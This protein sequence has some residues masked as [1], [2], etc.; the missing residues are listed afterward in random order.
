MEGKPIL[1]IDTALETCSV[2][3]AWE[4]GEVSGLQSSEIN[5]H[6]A[7]LATFVKQLLDESTL[8]IKDL[9]AVAVNG[10]PG[11]YTG[12]R[13]G[14]ALAKGLCVASSVP[15]ISISCL[16]A[17]AY[18]VVGKFKL[19][20]KDFVLS[21]IDA[22]REDVYFAMYQDSTLIGE[23]TAITLDQLW[24]KSLPRSSKIFGA[25][26]GIEKMSER[27]CDLHIEL[28]DTGI[29]VTLASSWAPLAWDA[30]RR[31]S[32]EDVSSFE[33]HYIKPFFTNSP[34]NTL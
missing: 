26:S 24:F 8:A 12:L 2:A 21:S 23:E 32:F 15:F 29:K 28:V 13:I 20:P 22:R 18:E 9:A 6:S 4:D 30:Y 33:P 3:L 5:M 10:G 1:C 34:P 11:S 14:I 31:E 17:L 27:I 25:G 19:S 16:Q 7:S